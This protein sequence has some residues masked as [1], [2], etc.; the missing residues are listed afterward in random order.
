M[1]NWDIIDIL[2]IKKQANYAYYGGQIM[3]NLEFSEST[4]REY[5]K[6]RKHPSNTRIRPDDVSLLDVLIEEQKRMSKTEEGKRLFDRI[7]AL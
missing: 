7:A 5:I 2:K 1:N 3:I 6:N 4:Y